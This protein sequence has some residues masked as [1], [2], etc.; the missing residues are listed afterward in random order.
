MTLRFEKAKCQHLFVSNFQGSYPGT[1][2]LLG[3]RK[4]L[5]PQGLEGPYWEYVYQ[6]NPCGVDNFQG[7]YG[8]L[9]DL[10]NSTMFSRLL[11]AAHMPSSCSSTDPPG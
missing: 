6:G 9:D 2:M 10:T 8:A 11:Q 1:T 7:K 5:V 3:L 4:P